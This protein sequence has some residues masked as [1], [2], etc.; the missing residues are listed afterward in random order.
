MKLP[1]FP[2]TDRDIRSGPER[3]FAIPA[4]L[5]PGMTRDALAVGSCR[6]DTPESLPELVGRN[7]LAGCHRMY[8]YAH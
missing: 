2:V 4:A 8:P 3:G 7:R 5:P 1:V 6:S